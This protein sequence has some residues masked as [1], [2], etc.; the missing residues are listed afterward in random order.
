MAQ[1][2]F[3]E[4]VTPVSP[5]HHRD[6][7]IE[8]VDYS[9]A[10]NVNA[11]P[12]AAAEMAAA[13]ADY[14]IVFAGQTG[15]TMPVIILGLER[16]KN[17]H[18]SDAGEWTTNY[19]PAFVQRYPFVFSQTDGGFMLCVDEQWAG[20]NREGRGDRLFDEQ[21]N[22]TEYLDGM[23]KF[24]GDSQVQAER[25]K[26]YCS[27]L[28]E[29]GLLEPMQAEFTLSSGENKSLGG[30]KAVNR[31]KVKELEPEKLAELSKTGELELTYVHLLS[32]NNLRR[33]PQLSTAQ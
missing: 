18:V 11:V 12:L 29:L 28:T 13:A 9:F 26:V 7:C 25:T 4:D 20:C 2:L 30:F 1:L 19:I 3:Y 10:S 17:Q 33:V 23:M 21:G 5:Q 24:L 22:R 8:R 16:G 27:H 32:M 6:L 14:P 15:N 31:Q